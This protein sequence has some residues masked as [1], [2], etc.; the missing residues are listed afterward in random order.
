MT[1]LVRA[2]EFMHLDRWNRNNNYR[3]VGV[4]FNAELSSTVILI[5]R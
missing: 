2:S 1:V 3:Q 5:I 4:G